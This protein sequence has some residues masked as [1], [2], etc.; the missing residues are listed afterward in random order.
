[1]YANNIFS[2]LGHIHALTCIY[3]LCLLPQ[4][5][6][7]P[8][9]GLKSMTTPS[10]TM[11]CPICCSLFMRLCVS[12]CLGV[13]VDSVHVCTRDQRCWKSDRNRFHLGVKSST[14]V[15]THEFQLP[16]LNTSHLDLRSVFLLIRP[17]KDRKSTSTFLYFI[18]L[19]GVKLWQ[20]FD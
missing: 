12:G 6:R 10:P 2:T 15:S 3:K 7:F 9:S 13:W 1:M 8:P 11:A 18:D 20:W 5:I 16:Q 19:S 17:H 14:C 4:S